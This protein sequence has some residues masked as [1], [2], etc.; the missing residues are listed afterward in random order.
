MQPA[1]H[2]QAGV[3]V[4]QSF[5]K[6]HEIIDPRERVARPGTVVLAVEAVSHPVEPGR[7]PV[8]RIAHQRGLEKSAQK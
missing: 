2:T 8:I 4:L 1:Q 5:K 3:P 6:G 7:Q